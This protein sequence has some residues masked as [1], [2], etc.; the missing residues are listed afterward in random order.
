MNRLLLKMLIP[1]MLALALLVALVQ[2][3]PHDDSALRE[4]LLPP[5]GCPAPCWQGV[6]PGI[7]RL[8][9]AAGMMEETDRL[10]SVER[11][12][13]YRGEVSA[14]AITVALLAHPGT[15]TDNPIIEA[16]R[17]KLPGITLGEIQ[18]ALGQADRMMIYSAPQ[19]GYTPLVAVYSRFSLYVLVDMPTCT[20]DQA[21][22]WNTTRYVEIMVGNWLEYSGDY[23]L[24]SRE[25]DV[26]RWAN[27]LRG[28]VH[29]D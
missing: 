25:L 5:E 6:R 13:R 28:A 11:P 4:L 2:A 17:L 14:A 7:T 9:A 18:L 16:V 19:R 26:N 21:T 22:L 27:Q 15:A 3:R 12:L 8:D 10:E 24:S 1:L 29:C 20:L 23:Y